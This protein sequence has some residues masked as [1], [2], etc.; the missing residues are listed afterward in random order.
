MLRDWNLGWKGCIYNQNIA[1]TNYRIMCIYIYIIMYYIYIYEYFKIC[2]QYCW[3]SNS[4]L[5]EFHTWA[6][7]QGEA[8]CWN[9]SKRWLIIRFIAEG[10]PGFM[11]NTTRD[12]YT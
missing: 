5:A 3:I 12:S 10:E 9:D 8:P 6:F 2:A 11:E 4:C 1:K 7:P